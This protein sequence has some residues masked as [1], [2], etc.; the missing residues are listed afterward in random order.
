[1]AINLTQQV[2]DYYAASM[3]LIQLK[4]ETLNSNLTE[5]TVIALTAP[6]NSASDAIAVINSEI[7]AQQALLAAANASQTSDLQTLSDNQDLLDNLTATYS[8]ADAELIYS[9]LYTK[10]LYMER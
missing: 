4:L 8:A 7:T 9:Y 3:T 5:L 2:Y 1:M 10:L 6:D